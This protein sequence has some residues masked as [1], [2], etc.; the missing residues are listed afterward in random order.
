MKCAPGLCKHCRHWK[1]LG[2]KLGLCRIVRPMRVAKGKR[3]GRFKFVDTLGQIVTSD[4]D[5][6]PQHYAPQPYAAPRIVTTADLAAAK[7][8]AQRQGGQSNSPSN[9]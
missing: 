8:A 2:G 3:G 5:G 7:I 1:A 4:C 6:C 9:F